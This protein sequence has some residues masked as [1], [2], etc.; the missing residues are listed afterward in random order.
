MINYTAENAPY[1][2]VALNHNGLIRDVNTTFLDWL[3]YE[4]DELIHTNME[5]LL[6]VA[7]KMMF[8]SLFFLQLQLNGR[9][10][11][12]HLTVRAKSGQTIPV[13]LMG[14]REHG[15]EEELLR[16]IAVKMAK[17]YDYEQELRHIKAE[18]EEAYKSKEA[19]L[20]EV[21]KSRDELLMFAAQV[22]G[23]LYQYEITPDGR[24]RMPFST[25]AIKDIFGCTPEEVRDDFSVVQKIIHPDDMNRMNAAIAESAE[26]L[27]PF[28]LE[29]RVLL[30]GQ[31]VRWI[32]TTSM[33]EKKEDGTIIFHGFSTDIT[34]RKRMED[35]LNKERELF[36]T[37]LMSVHDGIVMATMAGEILV[38]NAGAERITGHAGEEVLHQNI[39]DV[40]PLSHV[41]TGERVN[42]YIMDRLQ[43]GKQFDSVTDFLLTAKDGT[44][45]RI[46]LSIARINEADGEED[47]AIASFRDISR[48]YELEKQIQGFLDVNIDML[49][50]VDTDGK[51]HKVNK[52]FEEVLGYKTAELEGTMFLS[53]V[54]P[55]DMDSTLAA[56]SDLA[57]KK[58]VQGFSNRY[59]CRDGSYK[60]IEWFTQPGIGKFTYSSA[61]D[62]TPHH[63]REEQLRQAA[64]KDKLTGLYNRHYFEAVINEHMQRSDRYD[65]PL[66]LVLLDL[67]HFKQVNDTWGH[68]VGDELL[69]LI[70][71]T[72]SKVIRE[73]DI[74]FRLG[75]EEFAVLM[76]RTSLAGAL[77][78]AEKIR[79]AVKN[80]PLATVGI[81]TA[82]LGAAERMRA[83]SFRHWYRR[84]DEALYKA[85]QTGRNRVVASDGKERLPIT[86]INMKERLEL[87]SGN[88]E[89]DQ[90]HQELFEMGHRLISLLLDGANQEEIMKQLERLLS[91]TAD[92]FAHEE[93][94][95]KEVAYP[96]LEHHT[97]I[98]QELVAKAL[99]W[100][101]SY[102][103]GDI[104]ASAFF[105]FLVDD[106]ILNHM[107]SEDANFFSY[108][109]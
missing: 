87:Q 96:D 44:E 3:G 107:V 102:E 75:G 2:Y 85:K 38:F 86:A 33:P 92:H 98:H 41:Q 43:M 103:K 95:L 59:R 53:L 39:H 78:A 93:K 37:T 15:N 50:V 94:I 28:H 54:H 67:D 99:R 84:L 68:P 4:Y 51:F 24:V 57:N 21:K 52:K 106:V 58:S 109:K 7:G 6:S 108:L 47:R 14:H 71:R 73:A 16:C 63:Q 48:E 69:K 104:K 18:L 34:G 89:I 40:F 1:G 80:N 11:E 19:A 97:E 27:S 61:R 35:L 100:K 17:R 26:N 55:D 22:P 20:E 82:S 31:P 12:V 83:E 105:S 79:A 9:V 62:M 46:S 66:S 101:E 25:A 56:L 30:P 74:P 49:C 5:S 8:H 23:M 77:R 76:P 36:N 91:H 65:E 13:L 88:N 64:I 32:L 60:Y 10:D 29:Y 90:Q 72:V 45:K 42:E 70:A 81:R